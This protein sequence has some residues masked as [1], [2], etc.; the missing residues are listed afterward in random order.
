[1]KTVENTLT[2]AETFA[3]G[4]FIREEI[5]ARGWTQEDLA[6]VLGRPFQVVNEIINGKK[7]ITPETALA[8]GEAFGTSAE[9]W[10]NLE[11]SYRLAKARSMGGD[12]DVARRARIQSLVPVKELQKRGWLSKTNQLEKLE[13]EICDLLELS[14]ID[15]EPIIKFAARKNNNE[16]LNS[17]HVAWAFRAKHI[18]AQMQMTRFDRDCLAKLI[19]ELA[20]YSSRNDGIRLALEELAQVGI[21]V[22]ILEKLPRTR[23]DGAAFWLDENSPVV[24]LSLRYNRVDY[25]WFTLMHELAHILDERACAGRIDSNLLEED[26]DAESASEK[27][28]NERAASWLLPPTALKAFIQAN[29]PAFSAKSIQLFASNLGIHPGIVVGRLQYS[30]LISYRRHRSMLSAVSAAPKHR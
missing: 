3:P 7:E 19:P 22:L 30:K 15:E 24:A 28:A 18:A 17:S 14:S 8:L 25:F 23:I 16:T 12:P 29:S 4:E 20:R 5:E 1:M 13:R 27:K 26:A 21:R 9:L 11:S 2:L 10:L 6:L